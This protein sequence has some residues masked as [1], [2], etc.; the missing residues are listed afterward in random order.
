MRRI[1]LLLLI[2]SLAIVP[3]CNAEAISF[4]DALG[5]R[6]EL[7]QRPERV[8]VLFSSFAEM[9]TLAGG[10]VAV[11]VGETI[12]RGFAPADAALVDDGAGKSVNLELLI[13]LKPDFVICSADLEAQAEACGILKQAG[14][15]AARFRVEGFSDYLDVFGQMCALTGDDAAYASYGADVADQVDALLASPETSA[16]AGTRILFVRA[17]STASS[18]KAKTSAEHFVCEMLAELGCENI[19]DASN[20]LSDNLN[21]EYILTEDP[22]VIFF[23]LMG[24]ADAALANVNDLLS[25]PAWQ[26]LRAVREGNVHIL[27]KD[28]FHFKPNARW[29]EAYAYLIDALNGAQGDAA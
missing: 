24:D 13:S 27:P 11:T 9:W 17:G 20:Q 1:L 22:D 26:Q 21:M 16:A 25:Q 15:P 8:A 3:A 5:E 2:L 10:E 6:V 18:T 7:S 28:L 29:A 12:E 14:I 4:T 19:A 23:S